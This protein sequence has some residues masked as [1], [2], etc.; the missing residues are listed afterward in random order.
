MRPTYY[1]TPEPGEVQTVRDVNVA[2]ALAA[3]ISRDGA[4]NVTVANERGRVFAFFC[5]H[6]GMR[7]STMAELTCCEDE[8]LRAQTENDGDDGR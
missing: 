7:D 4:R 2:L 6:G 8:R 1:V 5:Q 3:T